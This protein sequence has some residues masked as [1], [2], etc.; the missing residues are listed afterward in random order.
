[1]VFYNFIWTVLWYQNKINWKLCFLGTTPT[2]SNT[3]TLSVFNQTFKLPEKYLPKKKKDKLNGKEKFI[4]ACTSDEWYK[5]HKEKEIKEDAK[6]QL[7]D[8]K[9]E[10]TEKKKRLGIEIKEIELKIL[11]VAGEEKKKLQEDKKALTDKKRN[12]D[13]EMKV[14]QSKIS[15]LNTKIKLE[16]V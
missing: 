8:E 1:M 7:Q 2:T 10:L 14:L 9:K 6:K 5:I 12:L 4:A 3:E 11:K 13:S 16:K 15:Q